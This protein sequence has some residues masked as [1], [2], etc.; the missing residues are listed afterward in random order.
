[1]DVVIEF[2]GRGKAGSYI[3]S[4][5]KAVKSWLSRNGIRVAGKVKISGV[6]DTP[7]LSERMPLQ[8]A[9]KGCRDRGKAKSIE[10]LSSCRQVRRSGL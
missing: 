8:A 3:H 9:N 5:V 10:H 4:N 6:D 7:T 1:M 2:E